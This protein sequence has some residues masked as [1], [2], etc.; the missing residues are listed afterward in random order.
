MRGRIAAIKM[1]AEWSDAAEHAWM[2]HWITPGVITEMSV[3]VTPLI[4]ARG[5]LVVN[6]KLCGRRS[7]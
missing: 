2:D 3:G 1:A 5:R 4:V 7:S 6:C